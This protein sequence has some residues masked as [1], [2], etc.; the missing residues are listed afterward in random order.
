MKASGTHCK[1]IQIAV[2]NLNDQIGTEE[3]Q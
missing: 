1:A 3:F 2:R